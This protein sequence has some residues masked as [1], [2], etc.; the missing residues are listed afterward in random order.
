VVMV[1]V[2]AVPEA[3]AA[4]KA[5]INDSSLYILTIASIKMCDCRIWSSD[6]V[7]MDYVQQSMIQIEFYYWTIKLHVCI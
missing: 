2:A 4:T 5:M 1:V 6:N 3:T 7:C